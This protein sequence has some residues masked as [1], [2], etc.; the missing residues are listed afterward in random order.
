MI[1]RE[2]TKVSIEAFMDMTQR[3]ENEGKR[4]ELVNGEV[5]EDRAGGT[6]GEHGEVGVHFTLVQ[7]MLVM[8]PG[9]MW[10]FKGRIFGAGTM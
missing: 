5:V 8:V 10:G 2:V 6:G 9:E 3:I 4:F 7:N 1:P